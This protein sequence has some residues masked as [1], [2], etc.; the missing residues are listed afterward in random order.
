VTGMNM[1]RVRFQDIKLS[2]NNFFI[3][4]YFLFFIN[5]KIIMENGRKLG[6]KTVVWEVRES[7]VSVV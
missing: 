7:F 6:R 5:S 1:I 4:I 3:Y 2:L